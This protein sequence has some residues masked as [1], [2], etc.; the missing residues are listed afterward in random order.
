[1]VFI[2]MICF[3]HYVCMYCIVPLMIKYI[4]TRNK[5][6]MKNSFC[7]ILTLAAAAPYRVCAYA[8]CFFRF[9][10]WIH[11]GRSEFI[12]H[13]FPFITWYTK[14]LKCLSS[15]K[16]RLRHLLWLVWNG[17]LRQREKVLLLFVFLKLLNF[18]DSGIVATSGWTK[19]SLMFKDIRGL[20]L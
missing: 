8:C 11:S 17:V 13:S 6:A 14:S 7:A 2:W 19:I 4:I 9:R 18:K 10:L 3:E 15:P 1:M 5:C 20:E 16:H 12:S